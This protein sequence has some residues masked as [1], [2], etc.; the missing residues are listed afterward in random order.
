[1]E[2]GG[3]GGHVSETSYPF[4]LPLVLFPLQGGFYTRTSMRSVRYEPTIHAKKV[5]HSTRIL[6]NVSPPL[7]PFSIFPFERRST[8]TSPPQLDALQRALLS[9]HVLPSGS[10]LHSPDLT[11]VLHLIPVVA[12]KDAYSAHHRN[13]RLR[14]S[15]PLP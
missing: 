1:V 5:N 8:S 6:T 10:P 11:F 4:N 15:P 9:L 13:H 2:V 3:G 7:P 14:T 12:V